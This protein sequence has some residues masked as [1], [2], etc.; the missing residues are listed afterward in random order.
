L[1]KNDDD[2]SE[3]NIGSRLIDAKE[4]RHNWRQIG[5]TIDYTSDNL[6]AKQSNKK[7]DV[8]KTQ[9]TSIASSKAR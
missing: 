2:N 7:R 4:D 5:L 9:S 3:T 1:N 8:S 6:N